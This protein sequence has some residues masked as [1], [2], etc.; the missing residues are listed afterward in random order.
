MKD[1]NIIKVLLTDLV[2]WEEKMIDVDNIPDALCK[3]EKSVVDEV[4]RSGELVKM[5]CV[6]GEPITEKTTITRH[7]YA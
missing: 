6:L 2:S 5:G 7:A 4:V 3:V 1:G